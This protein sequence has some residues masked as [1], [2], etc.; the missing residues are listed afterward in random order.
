MMI[1]LRQLFSKYTTQLD[2]LYSAQEAESLCFWLFEEYLG[3]KRLDIV[4]DGEL[5]E[6]PDSL[7]QAFEQLLEG[8]PI[9]YITGKAPFYGR[10]FE[11]GPEVLIPR[12]ET[13]ELVHL[14]IKENPQEGLKIL[15]IGTG[16]GC[17]PITLALELKQ[18]KIFAVDI[19]PEALNIAE[20]NS[21]KHGTSVIFR[22]LDILE[23]AIPIEAIDIL[24]SN[25]PYV[26]Y[27]EKEKMHKNVLEYEPHLALFVFDEDPLLFY[28]VIAEK[29]K[30]AL[31]PGGKLYF[32]I[33]ETLGDHVKGLLEE[34]GYVQVRIIK[35]LNGKDRI[36]TGQHV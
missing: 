30:K 3:K 33:N 8:K 18:P 11:V 24:V 34:L 20:R 16:S 2:S 9:Q 10:E 19:S 36:G 6:I 12:N 7:Q 32:E 22:K 17:I 5:Q 21:A 35:D 29:G 25:P 26:R 4:K 1:T 28:R 15:D 13:E 14:I 23:E 31:K 27:S